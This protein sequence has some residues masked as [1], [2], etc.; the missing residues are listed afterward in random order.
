M[1]WKLGEG[2]IEYLLCVRAHMTI[3][4]ITFPLSDP[5]Q[6]IHFF[7]LPHNCKYIKYVWQKAQI[8]LLFLKGGMMETL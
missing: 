1:L 8:P 7:T 6:L 2:V 5:G 3:T 4:Q